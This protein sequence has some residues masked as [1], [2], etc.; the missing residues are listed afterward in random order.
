MPS[1]TFPV[2]AFWAKNCASPSPYQSSTAQ[3][4]CSFF[5]PNYTG[6]ETSSY[7]FFFVAKRCV[8]YVRNMWLKWDIFGNLST[9]TAT[10]TAQDVYKWSVIP[11]RVN[12]FT[13]CFSSPNMATLPGVVGQLYPLSTAL[14]NTPTLENE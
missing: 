4:R 1:S 8:Q 3:L 6:Q 11:T 9:T 5:I 12:T 14:I 10:N 2:R 13:A 7:M